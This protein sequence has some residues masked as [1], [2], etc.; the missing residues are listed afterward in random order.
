VSE[1]G[2]G[3]GVELAAGHTSSSYL[4]E[5]LLRAAARF[6]RVFSRVE[7]PREPAS[8]RQRYADVLVDFELA[9]LQAAERGE[10][11]RFLCLEAERA[12]RFVGPDGEEPLAHKLAR[13]AAALPLV[14]VEKRRASECVPSISFEGRLHRGP[15]LV[16]LA[17][18]LRRRHFVSDGAAEA[19]SWL[20]THAASAGGPLSLEGQRFVLLGAG[21]ELA[22]TE[23]LLEA[24]AE[25]VWV[26]VREP[27]A[28]FLLDPRH[29]GVLHYVKGG[30]DLL[31]APHQVLATVRGFAETSGPVHLW[32]YAY[33]GGASQEWRLTAAMNAIVRALPPALLASV[34]VLVSPTTAASVTPA[35]AA[36]AEARRK[37]APAWKRALAATGQLRPGQRGDDGARVSCS[38]VPI[39]GVSYQAAQYLG[40]LLAAEATALYGSALGPELAPCTVSANVAPITATR[41]L[42]HP[43]FEAAFLG[44]PLFD[45][46]V[47]KP[48]TTRALAGL[49]A[50]HDVLNP[51]APGAAQRPLGSPRER[52][53]RLFTQQAHGGV[54]AQPFALEGEI[55]VAAVQGLAR[56]P[57]LALGLLR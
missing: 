50:V 4:H 54:Y 52:A 56:R 17:E 43:V 8:F 53:A 26:D 28:D 37:S 27:S 31:S 42:S 14:R 16:E 19:L 6:P 3:S 30:A 12:Y 41:S 32:M 24:G 1:K 2:K 38:I 23:L 55:A 46:L 49:L 18:E 44:A 9:R 47:A 25:V 33:A 36:T 7:L 40:K 10:I 11:A 29:A 35:D 13:E 21:A 22:P 51:Q 5:L 57:K 39:Q 48:S 20:A 15:A 34:G 45:I